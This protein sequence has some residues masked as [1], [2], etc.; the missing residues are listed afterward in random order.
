MLRLIEKIIDHLLNDFLYTALLLV[1]M[2][3]SLLAGDSWYKAKLQTDVKLA[4]IAAGQLV[5]CEKCNC[6]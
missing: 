2:L 6:K 3:L 1:I 5:E 4:K